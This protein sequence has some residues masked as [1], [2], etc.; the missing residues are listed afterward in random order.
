[1]TPLLH[2]LWLGRHRRPAAGARVQATPHDASEACPVG[3]T[4]DRLQADV[5]LAIKGAKVGSWNT[6]SLTLWGDTHFEPNPDTAEAHDLMGWW[7][8][9]GC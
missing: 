8:H 5:V 9:T 4:D 1:M 2:H 3:A 7:R 6:K